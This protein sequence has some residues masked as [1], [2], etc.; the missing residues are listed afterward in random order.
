MSYYSI[1]N[2]K[3]TKLNIKR[4]EFITNIKKVKNEE[5][6]KNYIKKISEKYKNATHNCWAYYVIEEIEKYNYS[7]NG[8]PSGTAGK[9]IFGQIEKYNLKNVAIVVTRYYGGIKLGVRGL[10]DA[11]SNSAE[12]SIKNCDIVEMNNSIKLICETDYSKFNE[13]EKLLKREK[14]WKIT[15]KNFTDKVEFQ[16]NIIENK[17]EEIINILKEKTNKIHENGFVEIALKMGDKNE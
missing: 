1:I 11:Y 7:D 4:S 5:A 2:E 14:G 10:I 13:I 15:E 9:P 8:E 16:I 3:E 12:N 17:S 6:A